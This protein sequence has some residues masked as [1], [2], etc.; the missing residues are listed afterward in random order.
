MFVMSIYRYFSHFMIIGSYTLDGHP[1]PY[2]YLGLTYNIIFMFVALP[3]FGWFLGQKGWKFITRIT[4]GVTIGINKIIMMILI[5]ISIDQNWDDPDNCMF[6]GSMPKTLINVF[7][8]MTLPFQS[9]YSFAMVL[10][11]TEH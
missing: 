4:F 5:L 10:A 3:T 6:Y 7:Y 2:A 9:L 8:L 1:N 11:K